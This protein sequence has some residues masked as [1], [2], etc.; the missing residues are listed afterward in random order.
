MKVDKN[1]EVI[2]PWQPDTQVQGAGNIRTQALASV[3]DYC[4]SFNGEFAGVG[5]YD[6]A[7]IKF[8]YGDMVEVFDHAPDLTTSPGGDLAP[9]ADYLAT[10]AD[11]D[12]SVKMLQDQ[13]ATDMLK[14]TRRLHYSTLPKYFGS[15]DNMYARSNK[16]WHDLKGNVCTDDT[17]CGAGKKCRVLGDAS[18]CADTSV[19]EVPYRFC[20]DELNGMTPTC[21]TFDEGADPYEIARNQ[22]D[23][24]E[25]Y[26]FFYGYARDS[27]TFS[28][29]TYSATVERAFLTAAR[30]YQFWAIDF[31]TYQK[32]GWWQKRYGREFDEDV[33]GG[34]SGAYATLNT[35]N[36]LT[37]VIARP[38]PGY[39]TYNGVRK[40]FEP[41]N[42]VDNISADAHWLDDLSG[43]RPLYPSYGGG[44]L[45]RPMSG[46]QIYDRLAAFQVLA[47][48]TTNFLANNETEDTRR[49]LVSFFNA[50][51][52]QLINLFAAI[53]VEDGSRYGW[54][55]LQGATDE[56]DYVQRRVWAGPGADT[57]P[58]LCAAFAPDATAADKIGCQKYTIFPD[59]R[60]TFPSS[61]FRMPLLGSLYGMSLLT[62][63]FNRAYMD[64]SRV[65]IKG[66]Q[67]SIDLPPDVTVATFTDPLSGK[68]YVAPMTANDT[69]NPGYEA[70]LLAAAELAKFN[71]LSLLQQNY[72]FSEYQFR[73]SLLDLIRTMHETYEY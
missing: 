52:R 59:G 33:N 23:Y 53:S 71:D 72:L 22:L 14:L 70:V 35:F 25:N 3:M 42:S 58:K 66:N 56:E 37:N 57:P 69:A 30:Q 60:P 12:P 6:K 31:A 68:T 27:E 2:N 20:S 49:Y 62:K 40:R 45:Y 17:Q 48:P 19:T 67:A 47:D 51:P 18:Y 73:V 24:Y 55:V 8:G 44:Y 16:S 32:D 61:R 63:G 38:T 15:V 7:A 9:M 41:Y 11:D 54:Y 28:P 39:F 36:T 34:L 13:G 46:G 29:N 26:W 50:F 21:A 4:A 65:F 10:P 64:V 43:A 5:L 1:G